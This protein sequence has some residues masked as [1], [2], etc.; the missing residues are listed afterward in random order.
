[1]DGRDKRGH[2]EPA[3]SVKNPWKL[4]ISLIP[5]LSGVVAAD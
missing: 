4:R 5:L 3:V 1:M 2:D